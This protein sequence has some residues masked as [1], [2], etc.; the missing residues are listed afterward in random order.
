M[1]IES[2]TKHLIYNIHE[3][4]LKHKNIRVNTDK[5][6]V[7]LFG[8]PQFLNY[9]DLAIAIAEINFLNR[10]F[11]NREL[12]LISEPSVDNG[13]D[14]VKSICNDSDIIAFH[15]GGNMGD[16]WPE[17]D[18]MRE[19]IFL[20]F[21]DSRIICFPQSTNYSSNRS[22]SLLR[23]SKTMRTLSDIWIFARDRSSYDF[24][25][26]NFPSNVH[27]NLVPDIVL[28]LKVSSK[29]NR[30]NI[31][32][33]MRS[34][35]EKEDNRVATDLI[36][37]ISKNNLVV[38]SDTEEI[39]WKHLITEKSLPKLVNSK[40]KEFQTS[41][42]I[43]TDRLHGMVFAAITGTPAIVFDNNN[44]KVRNL[45]EQWLSSYEYINFVENQD[46]EAI[47]NKVS[48][49]L[50]NKKSYMYSM[51]EELFSELKAAFII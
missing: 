25:K 40:L 39:Y 26:E 37:D 18:K 29:Y 8:I 5:N 4:L 33:F 51:D 23:I 3:F 2:K 34:D 12:I 20:E 9:G 6:R 11:P 16:V 13:I 44:H 36:S 46:E 24:M 27:I 31:A 50:D 30:T 10:Y 1:S 21:K 49:I 28:S 47:K 19:R 42:I 14:Q 15:G 22:E 43:L 48:S 17:Q 38:N 7:F 35:R 45:Y 32:T 41:K